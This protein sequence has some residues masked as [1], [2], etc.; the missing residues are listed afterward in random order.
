MPRGDRTGPRGAGPKTGRRMGYCVDGGLLNSTGYIDKEELGLGGWLRDSG[1]INL[2]SPKGALGGAK[3][4]GGAAL[5][6]TGIGAPFGGSLIG[7]GIGDMMGTIREGRGMLGGEGSLED[8][9]LIPP[10]R[11]TSAR[12]FSGGAVAPNIPT[13]QGGGL[14]ELPG[15]NNMRETQSIDKM[16]TE[17]DGPIHEEGGMDVA[18]SEVE[19]GE[20]L[21]RFKDMDGNIAR[22]IFSNTKMVPGKKI[23]FAAL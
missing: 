16:L 17:L 19:G 10:L 21:F 2:I 1:L 18:D 11:P 9:S 20:T 15:A 6:G 14:L 22:F 8:F 5:M 3:V 7:S 12:T 23:T 13:F 4:L